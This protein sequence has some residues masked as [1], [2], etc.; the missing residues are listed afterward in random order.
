MDKKKAQKKIKELSDALEDHN[1]RYYILA[2]PVI[3]D[4]A[5]DDLL[6]ELVELEELY[7]DLRLPY[8]PTQRIGT[9][10]PSGTRTV[11]HK[12]KMYSL[13]NTYSIED[14]KRWHERVCKSLE[15]Q[16][17][18]CTVELKI[19]GI[20]AS[21]SYEN[22]RFVLGATRGDGITGEDVTHSLKT[23]PTIPLKLRG[24]FPEILDV[25]CEVYINT[26]DF[27]KLNQQRKRNGEALFVNPRNATSGSVKLLDS[28]VT[29][30]RKLSCF[31]HSFGILEGGAVLKTQ[32]EFLEKIK[33]WGFCV[34]A[35]TRLCPTFEEVVAYCLEYQKM[36]ETIPYEVDGVVVKVNSLGGQGKLGAT[37]KSPRWAVAYKFPAHQVTSTVKRIVVQVGRT[38]VLTP[39]AE[40]EPAECAGV[41]I[42]RATLHNF[43]E[44]RRL[45]IKEGDCVLVERA[46]DVIP[47]IVKV[48]SVSVKSGG[49]IFQAPQKC[50]ECGSPISREN[51]EEVAYR[52]VNFS[53]SKQ[54]ER[55]LVHF[56]SRGAMDIEGLGPVVV[57]QL[58]DKGFVKELA[59]IYTLR[60][61]QL[62]KLELFKEKKADNLLEA[63][64]KSKKKDLS[65]FL[66]GLGIMNVGAKAAETLARRYGAI[67]QL[68]NTSIEDLE[69]IHE[70]GIVMAQSIWQFFQSDAAKQLIK[71]FK[72]AGLNLAESQSTQI[73][74]KLEGKKFVFT[75]E[76]KAMTRSQA[77][78]RVKMLGAK[79][80]GSVSPK[81]DFVVAGEATGLKYQKALKLGIT[82]LTEEQF[83]E[84]LQ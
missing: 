81:T 23:V 59:D 35:H 73:S 66:F 38:G 84:M 5:Y 17:V 82:I 50:P 9:K 65:Q 44:V 39:V 49:S 75:G 70:I 1:Y 79:L 37:A 13:D 57:T 40:L 2:Q 80:V 68:I 28:R 14:L 41:T 55:S 10:L 27:K 48:L 18:Q 58:L 31:V 25:R 56:A 62:L 6:K 53:C 4:K 77:G 74:H 60:K 15:T 26:E 43:D 83:R 76:L 8:S 12:T 45:G 47:K 36:R 64:E 32:G 72:Q 20:S 46:G 3:S 30:E 78:I 21:L 11:T 54:L 34:N 33:K 42:A 24:D 52:C 22:G 29:A 19:D 61:E 71:K 69:A 7:P 63:I 16:E 51:K 67:D